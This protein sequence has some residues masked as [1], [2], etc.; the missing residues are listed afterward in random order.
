M[1]NR[2]CYSCAPS[3]MYLFVLFSS[4]E[5]ALVKTDYIESVERSPHIYTST[6][7]LICYASPSSWRPY[8]IVQ[9][10]RHFVLRRVVVII[11]LKPLLAKRYLRYF[12]YYRGRRTVIMESFTAT[13]R[14]ILQ[15]LDCRDR[16]FE[17]RS[18]N[19]CSSLVFV[20]CCVGSSFCHEPIT[21][22]E[23]SYRVH[24]SNSVWSRNLN[25]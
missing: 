13:I 8:V 23:E 11:T 16:G 25:H 4:R 10:S 19:G 17:S 15:S 9:P 20:V 12:T 5:I 24:V 7:T 3:R 21:R 1:H 14:I 6:S 22:V 2:R 18:G